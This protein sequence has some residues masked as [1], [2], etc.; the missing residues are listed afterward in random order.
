MRRMARKIPTAVRIDPDSR[1]EIEGMIETGELKDISKFIR[2]AVREKL[3]QTRVSA[4][5]D[6]ESMDGIRHL[7]EIGDPDT[8]RLGNPEAGR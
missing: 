1:D 6:P 8:E 4:E 2:D 7:I 5:V 3:S